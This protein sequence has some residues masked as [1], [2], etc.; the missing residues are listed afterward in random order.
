MFVSGHPGN[1]ERLLTYAEL[2]FMR[3]L[4]VPQQ[5]ARLRQMSE[6]LKQLMAQSERAAFTYREQYFGVS[7]SLKAY[8]GHLAGGGHA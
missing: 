3:D 6:Q 4:R 5:V 2:T 1:T 7:N 8:E